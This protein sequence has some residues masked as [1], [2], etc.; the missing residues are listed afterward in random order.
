[1]LLILVAVR[2]YRH[3]QESTNQSQSGPRGAVAVP[4]ELSHATLMDIKELGNYTGTLKPRSGYTVAPKT[5]G[6][7]N[8][9]FVKLGDR[10]QNGQL[11][12]SLEDDLA[13]QQVEQAR[14]TLTVAQAQ[15]EHARLSLG[16]AEENWQA[17]K[18]LFEKSYASKAQMDQSDAEK[19][20]AQAKYDVS[21]A[22][23]QR[24]NASYKSSLIQLAYTQI[25]ASWTG[26]SN[27]RVVSEVFADEGS[28]VSANAPILSIV[29]NSDVIAE[30]EIIEKEYSKV[31]VGQTASISTDAYPGRSYSG[32]LARLAPVLSSSSRQARA[33]VEIPNPDASLKP[34]MYV[35]VALVYDQHSSVQVVPYSS[36]VTRNGKKGVYVED[37]DTDTAKFI[38]VSTGIQE[39][40]FIEIIEPELT[41][42]IVTLGMDQ[43]K[44]GSKIK[45]YD[46][47]QRPSQPSRKSGA[48]E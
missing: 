17:V 37:T 12:A 43:L 20:A 38:P 6:R 26:G 36:I 9:V 34:G 15:V 48:K 19:A 44:D 10:V 24:A 41:G 4:V 7:L 3:N 16:V 27:I 46:S 22:E 8:K 23:V 47:G 2:I 21:L 14:A 39:G 11:V 13:S 25:R 42:K 5:S 32:K 29:D 35:K 33:E 1:M 40:S 45:G 30:I 31:K 18:N 28:V